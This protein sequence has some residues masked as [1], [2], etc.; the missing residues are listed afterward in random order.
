MTRALLDDREF[1]KVAEEKSPLP[2]AVVMQ[3]LLLYKRHLLTIRRCYVRNF[4][5]YRNYIFLQ[6]NFISSLII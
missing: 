4:L 3:F 6:L 1:D 5:L 2:A